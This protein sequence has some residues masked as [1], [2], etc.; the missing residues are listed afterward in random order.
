MPSGLSQNNFFNNS[1]TRGGAIYGS[2]GDEFGQKL[3]IL[4]GSFSENSGAALYFDGS[5]VNM[6]DCV[7]F[8]NFGGGIYLFYTNA[9]V[10]NSSS[11]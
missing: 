10:Y 5:Y 4:G 2:Y 7:I 8:N 6:S 9:D 3:V 11:K 1:A